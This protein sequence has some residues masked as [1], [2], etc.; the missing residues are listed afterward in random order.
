MALTNVQNK[1]SEAV[2]SVD[3]FNAISLDKSKTMFKECLGTDFPFDVIEAAKKYV[4]Q[5]SNILNS[6]LDGLLCGSSIGDVTSMTKDLI[7]TTVDST[8]ETIDLFTSD[9]EEELEKARLP[10]DHTITSNDWIKSYDEQRGSYKTV[11]EINTDYNVGADYVD[12]DAVATCETCK[13]DLDT[14]KHEL[15]VS[16][17]I[18]V[19]VNNLYRGPND[20]RT[21][22]TDGENILSPVSGKFC[23]S[24]TKTI[25][26]SGLPPTYVQ[27]DA[28]DCQFSG[29]TGI[30]LKICGVIYGLKHNENNNSPKFT[31]VLAPL[32]YK[33]QWSDLSN[34][35][36]S[37]QQ[38]QVDEIKNAT[39]NNA[40]NH[41]LMGL[42]SQFMTS[43]EIDG[44]MDKALDSM[45]GS[46]EAFATVNKDNIKN[47]VKNTIANNAIALANGDPL[48][49]DDAVM[50]TIAGEVTASSI[51]AGLEKLGIDA[52][53]SSDCTKEL[54]GK[55]LELL[56]D[57]TLDN[58]FGGI[59][60]FI[61]T[62]ESIAF[63]KN[64]LDKL[65]ERFNQLMSAQCMQAI[66]NTFDVCSNN[67]AEATGHSLEL[68]NAASKGNA[69][70]A[71]AA[72]K[73]L[74]GKSPF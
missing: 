53:I 26:G 68:I 11:F 1:I 5:L 31:F 23:Y 8:S 21:M 39:T 25:T 16:L 55:V 66:N 45:L 30:D 3:N 70:G 54:I 34:T 6:G 67:I 2:A 14:D 43:S 36:T 46:N 59:T 51:N 40:K 58:P 12:V 52:N 37:Y 18:N 10:V 4:G 63:A 42:K 32:N 22:H 13:Y 71:N 56:P 19:T 64:I 24:K 35:L 17:D 41:A 20:G 57:A 65:N 72:K 44:A 50:A 73:Y 69:A 62:S 9:D 60:N 74:T 7:D 15:T 47:S 49:L 33:K 28:E 29:T 38:Q 61:D 48:T 27:F